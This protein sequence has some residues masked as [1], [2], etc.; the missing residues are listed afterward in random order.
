LLH[1]APHVAADFAG[2]IEAAVAALVEHPYSAQAT[3]HKGVRRK[4][5]RR[6]RYAI[7][8]QI[9]AAADELIILSIRHAAR[10]WPWQ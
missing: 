5:V 10:R 4:Y 7:F 8:Y 2:D 1:N 6:F 3:D 9:D